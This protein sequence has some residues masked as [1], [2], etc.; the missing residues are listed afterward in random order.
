MAADGKHKPKVW[1]K[2][3]DA[4][5]RNGLMRRISI[6]KSSRV[7]RYGEED[8]ENADNVNDYL[9]LAQVYSLFIDGEQQRWEK[10][11]DEVV[12]ISV[13]LEQESPKYIYHITTV[14]ADLQG[15]LDAY[16]CVPGAQLVRCTSSFV[17]WK[18]S[19][20]GGAWGLNF[21]SDEAADK[22]ISL[23][24]PS[25]NPQLKRSNS[26][27]C[28]ETSDLPE[29]SEYRNDADCKTPTGPSPVASC[30]IEDV[31]IDGLAYAGEP[32]SAEMTTEGRAEKTDWQKQ[33]SIPISGGVRRMLASR[34]N[35]RDVKYATYSSSRRSH[36][37]NSLYDN[38][39]DEEDPDEDY[40]CNKNASKWSY[41]DNHVTNS[42]RKAVP[43]DIPTQSEDSITPTP[44]KKV[45]SRDAETTSSGKNSRE[46]TPRHRPK[47]IINHTTLKKDGSAVSQ[48][49]PSPPEKITS[50]PSDQTLEASEGGLRPRS[51]TAT[52]RTSSNGS[53]RGS[54]KRR[55]SRKSKI[56]S[57]I[58]GSS[59]DPLSDVE[60]TQEHLAQT[61]SLLQAYELHMQNMNDKDDCD[62]VNSDSGFSPRPPSTRRSSSFKR[63]D[64][65]TVTCGSEGSSSGIMGE[66]GTLTSSEGHYSQGTDED[67]LDLENMKNF[68]LKDD[69]VEEDDSDSHSFS[70]LHSQASTYT[71]RGA[72]R[73]AGWLQCKSLLVQKK[74]RVERATNRKWKEYWVCLKGTMLLFYHCEDKTTPDENIEPRHILVV[75]GGI[76]Q[77]IPEHPKRDN[78]FCLSTAFG[79]AYLLQSQ[80]QIELENWITG[81]HSACASALARQHG[82]DDT[83]RLLKS[84]TQKLEAKV[85]SETKMKKMAELQLTVVTQ[86][87]NRQ[88]IVSQIA[89]WDQNLERFHLEL[90]RLR[91]YMAS[92]QG[93]EL[94]N[95][96]TLLACVS[97][98]TKHTLAKL[99]FFSVSSFHALVSARNPMGLKGRFSKPRS[100][101]QKGLFGTLKRASRGATALAADAAR[102]AESHNNTAAPP[103]QFE[104]S[105]QKSPDDDEAKANDL[106]ITQLF[107]RQMEE[108][109][110]KAKCL[111][112]ELVEGALVKV[113]LPDSQSTM[114]TL[115]PGMTVQ[116]LLISS[117]VNRQMDYHNYYV[118]FNQAMRFGAEV[119]IPDKN[120][121]LEKEKFDEIEICRKCI[122]QVELYKFNENMDFG[123]KVE[124]E[125][126]DDA[127][128]EDQLCV[129]ISEIEKGGLA[130]HQDLHVGDELL[131]IQGR[132]VCDLDMLYIE[133]L[134][135]TSSSVTLTVRSSRT[136]FAQ[137]QAMLDTNRYIDQLTCP[138]PPSQNRL[139][140]DMIDLLIIPGPNTYEESEGSDVSL[141]SST[142]SQGPSPLRYMYDPVEE[143]RQ[144]QERARQEED[145]RAK[146]S[147]QH[148]KQIEQ[149]LKGVEQITDFCR[150]MERPRTE[151]EAAAGKGGAEERDGEGAQMDDAAI[152]QQ[153]AQKLRKVILELQDTERAYV[154]DLN[155]LV[156]R[157]LE[158]LQSESFL[159][160][161]EIDALFGNI[162]EIIKFQTVFLKSLEDSTD[163]P[164]YDAFTDPA[165]FKRVLFSMGGAFLYYMD[166]FKLYSAFCACH[167]RSQKILDPAR[168]N[169]AL[170]EFL[171]ARN[172]KNQHS[173]SLASYLIKPIQRVLKYPLLLHEMRSQLDGNSEE[174]YHLSQAHKGMSQ[175]AGHINDM[176]RV[177]EE[178]GDIFDGLVSEQYHVKKESLLTQLVTR[179]HD[180][181][182]VADLA[183]DDLVMYNTAL[184]LN[185]QDD[186][187]KVKRGK[188]P[189]V[190]IFVFRP[191]VVIIC[192]ERTKKQRKASVKG[193]SQL[194]ED[195]IRFKWMI[196]VSSMQVKDASVSDSDY[197]SLW[198]LAHTKSEGKSEKFFQFSCS[199]SELKSLFVKTIKQIIRDHK[200]N[201]NTTT[202]GKF[203][204]GRPKTYT[205]YSG[206]RLEGLSQ[207]RRTLR[208]SLQRGES[209]QAE[210]SQCSEER[211]SG[212]GSMKGD[213][214]E[215]DQ[216]DSL[217]TDSNSTG[218]GSMGIKR[219][220]SLDSGMHSNDSSSLTGSNRD[221]DPLNT[222][223]N[224]NVQRMTQ[225][226]D[227]VFG[228][229]SCPLTPMSEG[230]DWAAVSKP[231]PVPLSQ[232]EIQERLA[233][234]DLSVTDDSMPRSSE[235]DI[236][237]ANR[238]LSM[239]GGA[240][241]VSNRSRRQ[242]LSQRSSLYDNM[243][244]DSV[245]EEEEEIKDTTDANSNVVPGIPGSYA[246]EQ[247]MT[248]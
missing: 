138:P 174:H 40:Q 101:K 50:C 221:S 21:I 175:V 53:S 89:Q 177:H 99:D 30:D 37:A 6:R 106:P 136:V 90:Y 55:G 8:E 232:K 66:L 29:P 95:P 110:S 27:V 1:N 215:G 115:R 238:T 2:L 180:A 25:D 203:T 75:E 235:S 147:E 127:E 229:P 52:S 192:K 119:K 102:V 17:Q 100:K 34:D 82:K 64:P 220:T 3:R 210:G 208:K 104:E 74:K 18:D 239:S 226:D 48:D 87:K 24:S 72:I 62:N 150:T 41:A 12:R 237:S 137:T 10:I 67:F 207:P 183:M 111:S 191:A 170:M 19:E 219:R 123:F 158:P 247:S 198:E 128:R 154:K 163:V 45:M 181:H 201:K 39:S 184:W 83:I 35:G 126:G 187:G 156:T 81:I 20:Q 59:T 179:L 134:L 193:N 186:L 118:K 214:S 218:Q 61:H 178:Y 244:C 228:S 4:V 22:F 212:S 217:E 117:C 79:D 49:L 77:A 153:S 92:L 94:P 54:T 28:L 107:E 32:G 125:L 248:L 246:N 132:V 231:S 166:H 189:E 96:K 43:G 206:K 146:D 223:V 36:F 148:P 167:S 68:A 152:L 196:P 31:V 9:L 108:D 60:N 240:V 70:S 209:S 7:R 133:N 85:E 185:S 236:A 169:K 130:Y 172:P 165:Q 213:R 159:T 194:T 151:E 44:I 155:L 164:E 129:F 5:N 113:Q 197:L 98:P 233:M 245:E 131:C 173:S 188:E 14:D 116:D 199:T 227:S 139:T 176:M 141:L 168:G 46:S 76:A 105:D 23:C 51:N 224:N 230:G 65:R 26:S 243:K 58:V 84:E 16:I 160:A 143:E 121:I 140:D 103:A 97:K 109:R 91:C 225:E 222:N 161:D 88:A 38:V 200:Y 57:L 112:E 114:V 204:L 234:M 145:R 122:H 144:R 142:P 80:S 33:I 124:A 11:V 42:N 241:P 171:E 120:A 195:I 242:R 216:F 93:S 157:Y 162:K 71:Q 13:T 135:Q 15:V 63:K 69:D 86:T 190:V 149:L 56:K 182:K 78:I 205:P 73:K 202:S 211:S 47:I